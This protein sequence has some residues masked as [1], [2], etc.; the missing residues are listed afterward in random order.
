MNSIHNDFLII[1][2]RPL[3]GGQFVPALRVP[4]NAKHS[5]VRR[6]LLRQGFDTT[7]WQIAREGEV[8]A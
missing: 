8:L 7:K 3:A 5:N 4:S 6:A 1:H 2:A